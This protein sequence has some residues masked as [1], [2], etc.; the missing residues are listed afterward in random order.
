MN[1]LRIGL[2]PDDSG[3]SGIDRRNLLLG[4]GTAVAT[5]FDVAGASKAKAQTSPSGPRI[6]AHTHFAPPRFL[7]FAENAEG[8][9]FPLTPLYKSKPSL[10]DVQARVDV[11]DHNSID[12]NVLVPVPWIEAF[13]KVYAD[14][15]LASEAA[16]IMNDELAT[17][18]SQALPWRCYFACCGPRCHGR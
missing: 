17:P 10:T 13:R 2:T 5:G 15:A 14:P 7:E 8:H 11:L 12:L 16:K 1:G 6:D 3:G 9:A 18:L 4:A